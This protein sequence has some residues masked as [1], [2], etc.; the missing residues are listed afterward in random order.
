MSLGLVGWIMG[1]VRGEIIAMF[2]VNTCWA[3]G[4]YTAFSAQ[5]VVTST[6]IYY[7]NNLNK[8]IYLCVLW[9]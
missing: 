2:G 7:D 4:T 6:A 5:T 9:F 8:I 3:S 1:M